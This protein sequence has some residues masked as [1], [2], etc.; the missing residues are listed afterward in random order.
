M[1]REWMLANRLTQEY[2]NGVDSFIKFATEHAR[3][4]KTTRSILCPCKRCL[5]LTRLGVDEVKGHMIMNGIDPTYTRWIWHGEKEHPNINLDELHNS[6]DYEGDR[7]EEMTKAVEENFRDHP[8]MFEDLLRDAREPLYPSC[9]KYTKLSTILKLYNLKA[10]HGWTDRSFTALLEVMKDILPDNNV[11]PNRTYDAKKAICSLAVDYERI[12]ACPNDCVLYRNEYESLNYCP[13]PNC[14][15]PRYQREGVAAK[16]VW[17]FP[18]IPRFKR[19]FA[20]APDAKN[21]RWHAEGREID[22][23][24]RHPADSEQWKNIDHLFPDF[25]KDPRN[26]RLALSADGMNPYGSQ[27]SI[28]STWPV[29]LAIYN[30]PSSLCMKR[31]YMMLSLL[32][33][34]PKQPGN[35]IDVYLQ[36][37]IDDLKVM[38]DS[39]VDVYDAHLDEIFSLRAMLLWTI[40]DFPAYG[41]LS[42]YSTKGHEACPICQNDTSYCQ[43]KNCQKT[44]YL[45]SRR[46]L[47]MDHRYRKLRKAFNGQPEEGSAPTSL[48]GQETLNV[49]NNLDITYGKKRDKPLPTKGWKKKSIFFTLSYWEHLSVR[50]CLD[51]MHIEKNICE[52]LLGTLLNVRGKTKDGIN[53]RLDMVEMGIRNELKPEKVG[54]RSY[55]PPACYTLSKKEK[56]LFCKFFQDIKVPSGFSSN[57]KSLVNMNELKLQGMKSHDCHIVMQELLPIAMRSCYEKFDADESKV[58]L[59]L[60]SASKKWS[61]FKHILTSHHLFTN[62]EKTQI[63]TEPPRD[64]SFIDRDTWAEFIQQRCSS[65]FQE[66]SE[67]NSKFAKLNDYPFKSAR[68]S[69]ASIEEEILI[70][71]GLDPTTFSLPRH[72]L[73]L[74]AR[75][76]NLGY[77]PR[78]MDVANNIDTIKEK[79]SQGQI[80][81][82]GR[83]DILSLALGKEDHSGRVRAIGAGVGLKTYFP[84]NRHRNLNNASQKRIN[85]LEEEM[86]I[87]K[88][89]NAARDQMM[90]QL[91]TQLEF[92]QNKWKE[93]HGEEPHVQESSPRNDND[94][95]SNTHSP[96][97]EEQTQTERWEKC[98]LFW[99]DLRSKVAEGRVAIPP[100][101]KATMLHCQ[102]LKSDR[103]KVLVDDP[104][105]PNVHVPFPTE[106]VNTVVEA[107]SSPVAWPKGLVIVVQNQNSKGTRSSS[108]KEKNM[109]TDRYRPSQ[110]VGLLEKYRV[111]CPS[112]PTNFV[113]TLD[114][115]KDVFNFQHQLHVE[116]KHIEAWIQKNAL[117]NIHIAVYMKYL[118][119]SLSSS[120]YGFLCPTYLAEGNNVSEE[121]KARYMAN[122]MSQPQ[123][124]N[125]VWFAPYKDGCH[126]TLAVINPW[127]NIV[128]L[129]DLL[130][131]GVPANKFKDMANA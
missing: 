31:K 43:L 14:L 106:E 120:H 33:S 98:S 77:E 116:K 39:G 48:N 5:N 18:I 10:A 30:L 75:K 81:L 80:S 109:D 85:E 91:K 12:H 9:T 38:W 24:L 4:T 44:V 117:D 93:A 58:R 103:V 97:I 69:Y 32:I 76:T 46:F 49:V 20:N 121:E 101:G 95:C 99:P 27:S 115:A 73:W 21:L 87:L 28:H 96:Q 127:D 105:M 11:L 74:A 67:R 52:S 131:K 129:L 34:G 118:N 36:P 45:G 60:L 29:V 65:E 72:E 123:K 37:L 61:D 112:F 100:Q 56:V 94:R 82:E 8:S 107:K 53:A 3:T 119:E 19:M 113:I 40:N 15:R 35:D 68:K 104:L 79:A 50:H 62:A 126:W 23:N 55:L 59:I 84:D 16:V 71:Q 51:V 114:V 57:V 124:K 130:R 47:P 128:F 7:L 6:Q 86:G 70:E 89:Q 22:G 78:V 90:E 42:G 25:A 54:N 88:Q 122:C 83:E 26:L 63:R 110:H 64:F 13:N 2:S 66:I 125:C 92:F 41:N 108:H 111:T 17:Y 102:P 1:N